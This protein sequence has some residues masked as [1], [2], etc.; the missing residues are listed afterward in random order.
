[1]SHVIDVLVDPLALGLMQRAFLVTAAAAIVC[2]L[3]SCWLVL[4]GWSLMGDALSHAVLPGVV[5]AYVVGVPFTL[6]ALAFGLAAAGLIGVVRDRTRLAEDAAI[7]VV[8]TTLFALGLVL[9]SLNPAQVDLQHILLGNVLGVSVADTIQVLALAA[10]TTTVLLVKRR[11]LTL[12]AFDPTYAHAIGLSPRRIAALLLGLL[13]LT[14]V[15]AL[16]AIGVILVVAMLVIPGA[17]ARLLTE[18][19]GVMLV[20]APATALACAVVGLYL[21]YYAG[22]SSGGAVVLAQG[23]LFGVVA[24]VTQLRRRRPAGGPTAHAASAEAA[25]RSGV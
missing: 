23:V 7:G 20:V 9:V 4:I 3:L 17:T 15:V 18:R 5:L 12:Y 19:F 25:L 10:V 21:S 2:A 8:F 13:A 1:M 22:V 16:Q 24:L 11:D 14:I 6:G